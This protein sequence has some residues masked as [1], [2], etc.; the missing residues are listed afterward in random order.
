[1]TKEPS[2][3]QQLIGD[4]APK[5]VELT[6]E[7]LFGDVWERPGLSK[8]DRSLITV[9]ALVALYRTRGIAG[10]SR[11]RADQWRDQGRAGRAH[12]APRLL[13]RLAERDVGDAWRPRRCS[14]PP[15]RKA[16]R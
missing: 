11:P 6:D 15:T 5:L 9:A 12:H 3:A 1:M 16:P 4:V 14:P 10:P 7:V 2:R 8:R 13:R